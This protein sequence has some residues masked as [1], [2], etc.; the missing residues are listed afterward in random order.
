MK[1]IYITEESK[2]EIEH[3]IAELEKQIDDHREVA[4]VFFGL[5]G[6][7]LILKEI[8]SLATIIPVEENWENIKDMLDINTFPISYKKG[9]IIKPKE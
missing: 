8:L 6:R 3:K 7:N 1:G 2:K 5:S 9:V 4:S